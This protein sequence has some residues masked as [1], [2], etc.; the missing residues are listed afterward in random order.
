MK[1][2]ALSTKGVL[3]NPAPE[4]HIVELGACA[5]KLNM[6]VYVTDYKLSWVIPDRI[7]RLILKQFEVE[8]IEIPYP[9]TNIIMKRPADQGTPQTVAPT[10]TIR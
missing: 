2:I 1:E 8:G 4:V 3:D 5:V 7:Y 6:H 10:N 9:I